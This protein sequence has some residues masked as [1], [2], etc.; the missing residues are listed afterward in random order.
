MEKIL[1]LYGIALEISKLSKDTRKVGAVI[2]N[3]DLVILA[4]GYNGPPRGVLDTAARFEYPLKLIYASHAEANAIAQAAN[5]G[6]RLKDSWLLVTELRPCAACTKLII[7]A[8]IKK[9][10]YPR[11]DEQVLASSKWSE[12]WRHSKI[13]FLEANI[14]VYEYEPPERK[15]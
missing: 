10:A 2:C 5:E 11:L 1:K 8:G 14:E 9:V 7:Q 6:V 4:M 15:T 12:E 3:S 13:M